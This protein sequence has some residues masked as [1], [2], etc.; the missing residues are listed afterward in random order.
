M[1]LINNDYFESGDIKTALQEAFT[2]T[3]RQYLAKCQ[4]EGKKSGST[5]VCCLIEDKSKI[6]F[7][8][9]GDSLAV[10]FKN[11]QPQ[12]I[13]SP[14]KP[15]RPDE[16]IR[17]EKEGGVVNFQDTW[18]VNGT[19][20][21]SRAIGDPEFKPWVISDPDINEVTLDGSEDFLIL[22]CDGLWDHVLLEDTG[23]L[24][25]HH[26]VEASS[27]SPTKIV[28][29]CSKKLVECAKEGGSSDNITAIVVFLR[30]INDIQKA[31]SSMNVNQD[32]GSSNE[33]NI[34]LS[35]MEMPVSSFFANTNSSALVED[36]SR[37]KGPE[38]HQS[39]NQ[40]GHTED[41]NTAIESNINENITHTKA[42]LNPFAD[43]GDFQ[44][45][46][47]DSISDFNN[48][49]GNKCDYS[50]AHQDEPDQSVNFGAASN[51][52]EKVEPYNQPAEDENIMASKSIEHE[53]LESNKPGDQTGQMDD[54]NST[55]FTNQMN[56]NDQISNKT[57]QEF[58]P[59]PAATN[60]T[61]SQPLFSLSSSSSTSAYRSSNDDFGLPQEPALSAESVGNVPLGSVSQVESA[62]NTD[63]SHSFFSIPS[64]I[65]SSSLS[66][67]SQTFTPPAT[68][69]SFTT[70]TNTTSAIA[71]VDTT[72]TTTTTATINSTDNSKLETGMSEILS[73]SDVFMPTSDAVTALTDPTVPT[74]STV[75]VCD[76]PPE[77][78]ASNVSPKNFVADNFVSNSNLHDSDS[79]SSTSDM[80]LACAPSLSLYQE[81]DAPFNDSSSPNQSFNNSQ[82]MFDPI[83]QVVTSNMSSATSIP[84]NTSLLISS[85]DP[86]QITNENE[87]NKAL[88][89]V[90]NKPNQ[91][92]PVEKKDS[93]SLNCTSPSIPADE[94]EFVNSY[95][96][97]RVADIKAKDSKVQSISKSLKETTES[98][99][100]IIAQAESM[101][102]ANQV[103]N[104]KLAASEQ[105]KDKTSVTIKSN[106]KRVSGNNLVSSMKGTSK[107]SQ[108]SLGTAKQ[109]ISS[110]EKPAANKIVKDGVKKTVST[111][112]A[113]PAKAPI[114]KAASS[115]ATKTT[116]ARKATTATASTVSSKALPKLGNTGTTGSTVRK[117]ATTNDTVSSTLAARKVPTKPPN[118]SKTATGAASTTAT[119]STRKVAPV[120]SSSLASKPIVKTTA[121]TTTTTQSN[122]QSTTCRVALAGSSTLAN[123]VP[124]TKTSASK[125]S[126]TTT[127]TKRYSVGAS[128]ATATKSAVSST[129]STTKRLSTSNTKDKPNTISEEKK[130][131]LSKLVTT[132]PKTTP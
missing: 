104:Q 91:A 18:R 100:D 5:A 62:L 3:D 20:A 111:I 75:S 15:N 56:F 115:V 36:V 73:C 30:E 48:Q 116:T 11:G 55:K 80:P 79:L 99:A 4:S 124:T 8:W 117:I 97:D 2:A 70:N 38:D 90:I 42:D 46:S 26:L 59:K 12:E 84:S 53:K 120:I 40:K 88:D 85:N 21:V 130:S 22:A 81:P 47:F 33:A 51:L 58:W 101:S 112:S 9:V 43:Q 106:S 28:E 24:V 132:V 7:A 19:L 31:L 14:H 87:E 67:E 50:H 94:F 107:P 61:E 68:A 71:T 89:S 54:F 69:T 60:Q 118:T 129:L 6:Y 95:K 78:S 108:V 77:T 35:N 76:V 39:T 119:L 113:K 29:E 65:F 23:C 37:E 45:N 16:M 98:M 105:S 82:N 109:K 27:Q 10:L 63:T 25:Y 83:N 96:S 41:N 103:S 57:D 66:P 13:M 32:I 86:G 92:D 121:T 1:N 52:F 17:I 131:V 34:C 74:F 44:P 128:N 125:V 114:S 93:S 122:T 64:S 72:S 123:K 110:T 102:L 126:S 127:S 49:N